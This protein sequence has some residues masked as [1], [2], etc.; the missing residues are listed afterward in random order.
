MYSLHYESK[1]YFLLFFQ[2]RK[3]NI[4]LNDHLTSATHFFALL[5]ISF[6]EKNQT[7]CS[8][9]FSLHAQM[10]H[11]Y[12]LVIRNVSNLKTKNVEIFLS[13]TNDLFIW[14]NAM[15]F[16]HYK[17]ISKYWQTEQLIF[18]LYLISMRSIFERYNNEQENHQLLSP[19]SEAKVFF[20]EQLTYY[21]AS[22]PAL[23][24]DI[25]LGFVFE[26]ID[27]KAKIFWQTV[28]IL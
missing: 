13:V 5:F 28:L 22:F 3:I 9:V 25:Q 10:P 21:P 26:Y 20:H 11:N 15:K 16:L 8:I 27:L 4:I 23:V 1:Q 7:H 19:N 6:R 14:Y 2:Q 12:D 17:F 24:Q 18:W